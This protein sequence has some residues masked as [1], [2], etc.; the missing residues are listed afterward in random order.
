MARTTKVRQTLTAVKQY[1]V[2]GYNAGSS[3]KELA[4]AYNTCAGTIRNFLIAEGVTLRSRGRRKN[5][6]VEQTTPENE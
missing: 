4:Q 2:D 5:V 6:V 3:L 1:L